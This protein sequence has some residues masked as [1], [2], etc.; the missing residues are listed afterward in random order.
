MHSDLL[1]HATVSIITQLLTFCCSR[2]DSEI[3]LTAFHVSNYLKIV[4][5]KLAEDWQRDREL[6]RKEEMAQIMNA[7]LAARGELLSKSTKQTSIPAHEVEDYDAFF[8]GSLD[9]T[10]MNV[11]N[12]DD[13]WHAD[14]QKA[15]SSSSRNWLP[16]CGDKVVYNRMLHGKF[17]NGHL[18]SLKG[19]QR[20]L[21][22]VLPPSS[23]KLKKIV[24]LS[25]KNPDN[26][27]DKS[28]SEV[29]QYFLGTIMW[30]R[31]VFPNPEADQTSDD[32]CPLYAI[33][34]KFHYKWLAKSIQVVY[35]KP[36]TTKA[37]NEVATDSTCTSHDGDSSNTCKCCAL[38]LHHSFLSPA[39][40]GPADRILP[41]FPLSLAHVEK[42]TGIPVNTIQKIDKCLGA[43]KGRIVNN[44]SID[45]F[46]RHQDLLTLGE[47]FETADVPERYRHIFDEPEDAN[48]SNMEVTDVSS[49]SQ[50]RQLSKVAFFAPWT[51]S[52]DEGIKTH[53]STRGKNSLVVK[54]GEVARPLHETVLAN[55]RLSL[56]LIHDRLKSGFYRC[57][58]AIAD[59]IREA[60]AAYILYVVKERILSKRLSKSSEETVLKA[61]IEA[62]GVDIDAILIVKSTSQK[63]TKAGPTAKNQA[64]E[65][66][67][68]DTQVGEVSMP[69]KKKPLLNLSDLSPQERAVFDDI[70]SVHKLYA[71]AM[72]A[73]LE[74]P[75]AEVAFGL[76][77]QDFN[78]KQGPLTD[79]QELARRNL[80]LMLSSI[81]VDKMKF[82]KQ[83]SSGD[84]SPT[85]KVTVQVKSEE[86]THTASD[87][88]LIDQEIDQGMPDTM[89]LRPCDY[90][91]NS[92]LLK[93]L[94]S[95]AKGSS[96][97]DIQ[98]TVKMQDNEV[99][100]GSTP[101]I[102]QPDD[103]EKNLR[104]LKFL[105]PF[106]RGQVLPSIE[107]FICSKDREV[108]GFDAENE[109]SK[110]EDE[111]PTI[112]VIEEN[113]D[114][115]SK[116]DDGGSESEKDA[117]GVDKESTEDIATDEKDEADVED[118]VDMS[119]PLLFEP[120]DYYNNGSH[121]S[122]IGRAHV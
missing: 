18:D 54:S 16:Q 78:Q 72:V 32:A 28:G 94:G 86:E 69:T 9:R 112:A 1:D 39:W 57:N 22:S 99:V 120:S 36:C 114:S 10:W 3:V 103:Y 113:G 14:D 34:I 47:A 97:P 2:P 53:A 96:L 33:G 84:D 71:T 50:M 76:E 7:E 62:C 8:D 119:E 83:L 68:E 100:R 89:L 81:A 101:I 11:I 23:K 26:G 21:P 93:V 111:E 55:P 74:T 65:M 92:S 31:A 70:R 88:A 24:E 29:Y 41:P 60:C 117:D 6:K 42:P 80:N 67:T 27:D 63:S 15:A 12:P 45:E 38:S 58:A 56:A 122:K 37:N 116:N 40:I 91:H 105:G 64:S 77:S 59:D 98:V 75:T 20:S 48:D 107:V 73:C 102:L 115:E 61:A 13:T 52:A 108:A 109:C 46:Q 25:K 43:L 17:I 79:E 85:V 121:I 4:A 87:I 110:V 90:E 95:F 35:W 118:D 51:L 44:T 66:S 19:C 106:K 5:D 49:L 82:R 104:L 30:M